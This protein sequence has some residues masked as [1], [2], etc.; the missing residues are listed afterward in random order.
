MKYLLLLSTALLIT[1]F[2]NA[3]SAKKIIEGGLVVKSKEKIFLSW[4]NNTLLFDVS[5]TPGNPLPL[6]DS[7]YFLVKDLGIN[8][9]MRPLNPLN[10]STSS[11][12]TFTEDEID[13]NAAAAFTSIIGL[14]TQLGLPAAAPPVPAPG[15]AP[16]PAPA[17]P[18]S[19]CDKAQN[20]LITDIT[21]A[22]TQLSN[23]QKPTLTAIF[24][25]LQALTFKEEEQTIRGIGAIGRRLEKVKA[26]FDSISTSLGV[27]KGDIDAY[28][29][30]CTVDPNV[31]T[32]RYV[33]NQMLKELTISY[34]AQFKRWTNVSKANDLVVAAEEEA[35]GPKDGVRWLMDPQR[36][37]M[38]SSKIGN[39]TVTVNTDG[40]V[41]SDDQEVVAA[42]KKQISSRTLLFRTFQ[43]WV[44]E[45]S[46]GVAYTWLKFPKYGT[47]TDSAGV[48]HVA[49]A[50]NDVIKQLN[51]TAMINMVYYI[52]QS[53]IAPFVQLG[54]GANSSYPTILLG[55]GLR[56]TQGVNRIAIAG[57]FCGAW[58]QTLKTLKL[59]DI[60]TGSAEIDKDKQ[61][62][63]SFPLKP[64]VS[65]QYNF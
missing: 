43:H 12:V 35:S 29:N 26:H 27:I 65:I 21:N 7:V 32:K 61:Y 15:V 2:S 58:I 41:L 38:Q 24:G 46:A 48:Q 9:Y 45:V 23:D 4:E 37:V 53:A 18:L 51:F 36:I 44:P 10:L 64:Y 8:V 3:Q 28:N 62:E 13:Q 20:K 56:I 6:P 49:D 42:T 54:V 1:F 40:L 47:S 14:L 34:T 63:F 17:P 19:D 60:V 59:N 30:K 52:P 31:F 16:I 22:T 57:G 55:G 25:S 11:T 5:V 33:Y 39:L 50:G